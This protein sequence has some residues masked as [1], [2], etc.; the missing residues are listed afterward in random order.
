[1]KILVTGGTGFVGSHLVEGL[2]AL[3]HD[4]VCLV[5]NPAKVDRL[6][7]T[8]KPRMVVGDLD[9]TQAVTTAVANADAIYHVAGITTARNRHEFHRVN[10]QGTQTLVRI[11][12]KHGTEGVR[13]VYMSSLAACG[14]ARKGRVDAST[15]PQPVS[16]YGWSKLGGEEAV[17]RS[18]LHW[19]ILRPPTVYGPRDKEL[20]KLFKLARLG[21]V[22]VF[23]SGE[24]ANSFVFVSDLVDACARCLDS[25]EHG[26]YFPCH[27]SIYTQRELAQLVGNAVR[28][29]SRVMPIPNAIAR[30]ALWTTGTLARL[31]RRATLLNADRANDFLAP[32][33]TCSPTDLERILGWNANVDLNDGLT[34]TA[35]WYRSAQWL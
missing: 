29:R 31:A 17:R 3:G 14:P 5:R 4:V 21:I 7:T 30:G 18:R 8:Q 6:F 20:L 33:W 28:G 12:E 19:T 23:G 26:V 25:P 24:Q 27:P 13:F 9:A 16:Q 10:I 1:M 35:D 34:T 11:A 22:P 2:L 32:A 15:K